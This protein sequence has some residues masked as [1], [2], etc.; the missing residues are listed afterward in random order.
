[1]PHNIGQ[2]AVRANQ[3]V[4]MSVIHADVHSVVLQVK[5]NYGEPSLGNDIYKLYI[6]NGKLGGLDEA[7]TV[8]YV[9][10]TEGIL[11]IRPFESR[12]LLLVDPN[13]D[14]P[15]LL[16]KALLSKEEQISF[17]KWEKNPTIPPEDGLQLVK[18]AGNTF[19]F[20]HSALSG[21]VDELTYTLTR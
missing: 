19:I 16:Y 2:S 3:Y 12:T 18:R 4:G 21:T 1:M 20:K 8:E 6:Y 5:H 14:A 15:I 9:S 10:A 17:E 7:Y 11:L 13:L